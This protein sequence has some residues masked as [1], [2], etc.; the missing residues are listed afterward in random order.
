MAAAGEAGLLVADFYQE[1][2]AYLLLSPLAELQVLW[3]LLHLP[4][5]CLHFMACRPV[6]L[7]TSSVKRR[8]S[9]KAKIA[10]EFCRFSGTALQ[11]LSHF[12]EMAVIMLQANS[13]VKE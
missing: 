1:G 12:R 11:S 3:L 9:R 4:V 5:V 10:L 6:S 13:A 7:F 2:S 8:V